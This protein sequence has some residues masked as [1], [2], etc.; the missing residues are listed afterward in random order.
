[1]LNIRSV[2]VGVSGLVLTSDEILLLKQYLPLGVI[3]FSRNINN[4]IQ[5][6]ELIK[7]I[8][9]LLGYNCLILIDQEGG[10]VQ[11]LKEPNCP[12]YPAASIFGK[13]AEESIQD[14]ERAVYLNYYLI[15]K[16]LI[17][18]GINVNCAPCLDVKSI[19]TH[20]V[21]G[22]RSFSSNPKIVSLLGKAACN[23]LIESGV[24]PIIKHIP[25][26]G[27]AS[28]DS[29]LS[30]PIVNDKLTA[31]KQSDFIPFKDLSNMPIAMTAHILFKDIDP[32]YPVTL[33]KLANSYIRNNLQ[34]NGILISDDIEMS[35]LKG[36]LKSK[37]GA[38][39]EADY[40]IV[41]H[42]AGD[43]NSTE[44]VLKNGNI[45]SNALYKKVLSALEII[46]NKSTIDNLFSYKAELNNILKKTS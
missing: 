24:L 15:G 32:N 29:H 7:N 26:H 46:N 31:L 25:G 22:D 1:M 30:L 36:S 27:K 35:A 3:L 8:K 42:C 21:I 5:V 33:S 12:N 4:N 23:G 41:L 2:I 28:S 37:I 45:M 34:F 39:Y 9:N 44:T 20:E 18:L 40:D 11:R 19:T 43:I 13:L 17:N 38:I 6:A 14:A 16:N 10:R